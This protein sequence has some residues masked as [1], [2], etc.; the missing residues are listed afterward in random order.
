MAK[1]I[2]NFL[3]T[4][5]CTAALAAA[6]ASSLAYEYHL[7]KAGEVCQKK[8]ASGSW[9][10]CG[11][12]SASGTISFTNTGPHEVIV[13]T[14]GGRGVEVLPVAGIPIVNRAEDT[15]VAQ[16]KTLKPD[17][18]GSFSLT[19]TNPRVYIGRADHMATNRTIAITFNEAP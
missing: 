7:I 17:D 5:L 3:G 9:H 6:A 16:Q 14:T 11:E 18:S 2:L 4:L 13:F 19:N 15:G 1:R 12:V 8:V 10:L